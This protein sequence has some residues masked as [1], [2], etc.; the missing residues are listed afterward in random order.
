MRHKT[1][2]SVQNEIAKEKLHLQHY[3]PLE[4]F[5]SFYTIFLSYQKNSFCTRRGDG[6]GGGGGRRRRT[7]QKRFARSINEKQKQRHNKKTQK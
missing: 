2:K 6:G 1:K 7:F 4:I 3:T 5:L